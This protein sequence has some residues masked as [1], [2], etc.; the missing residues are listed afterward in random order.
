MLTRGLSNHAGCLS[1]MAGLA[2][3]LTAATA[4]GQ[5]VWTG[6][7]DGTTFSSLAN[8]N[9][10]P[11][12]APTLS[13]GNLQ[14]GTAGTTTVTIDAA[15]TNFQTITFNAGAGAFTLAGNPIVFGSIGSITNNS[16]SLQTFGSAITANS[17]RLTINAV[18]G[19]LDFTG[20]PITALTGTTF[21]VDAART[22][23]LGLI[24][25]GVGVIKNGAGTL[26]MLGAGSF[27]GGLTING[28][29]VDIMAPQ[30]FTGGITLNA[31]ELVRSDTNAFGGNV[32]SI[33]AGTLTDN[34]TGDITNSLSVD[35]NFTLRSTN[36]TP[37]ITFSGAQIDF[38]QGVRTITLADG[39]T[40]NP[41]V[42]IG[43]TV[44]NGGVIFNGAGNVNI[45]AT[46][47]ALTDLFGVD[48]T[49]TATI[50][51]GTGNPFSRTSAVNVGANATLDVT[52]TNPEWGGLT[53]S[54]TIVGSGGLFLT[55]EGAAT[56]TFSGTLTAGGATIRKAGT[57]TQ[58][59]S[60]TGA[61]ITTAGSPNAAI[62][63]EGTLSVTNGAFAFFDA[64][65]LIS[66]G[67]DTDPNVAT[68]TLDATLLI[69]PDATLQLGGA[70]DVGGITTTSLGGTASSYLI[71]L[72]G[73]TS[74]LVLQAGTSN[75]IG[76]SI[77]GT[78]ATSVATLAGS[79]TI[80]TDVSGSTADLFVAA[81]SSLIPG[82]VTQL[83]GS[84]FIIDQGDSGIGSL[85]FTDV[86]VTVEAGGT[87]WARIGGSTGLQSSQLLVNRNLTLDANSTIVVDLVGSGFVGPG[88]EFVIADVDGTLSA[89]V[90][91]ITLSP[92]DAGS[93]TF[94]VFTSAGNDQLIVR[95]DTLDNPF[96][97][98][99]DLDNNTSIG[100]SF[101]SIANI[102]GADRTTDQNSLLGTLT[103]IAQT[104]TVQYNNLIRGINDGVRAQPFAST[105]GLRLS[106]QFVVAQQEYVN[107]RLQGS[108]TI[109][110]RQ[111]TDTFGAGA[112][113]DAFLD[114]PTLANASQPN[115]DNAGWNRIPRAERQAARE[116]E[117][118]RAVETPAGAG[119]VT[120]PVTNWGKASGFETYAKAFGVF[121][122]EDS[123][124]EFTGFESTSVGGQVG[125][126]T[127]FS[128][129]LVGL[130]FSYARS[131]LDLNDN[132][133]EVDANTYRIGPYYAWDLTDGY[134][135]FIGDVS[136]N[137]G[138]HDLEGERGDALGFYDYETEAYDVTA[139]AGLGYRFA[140]PQTGFSFTPKGTLLFQYYYQDGY[141]ESGT[142]LTRSDV[143]SIDLTQVA[144]R[145][146]NDLAY[147]YVTDSGRRIIPSIGVGYLG[148]VD[149]N[150]GEIDS[151]FQVGGIPYVV[152]LDTEG[153][154]SVLWNVG[155]IGDITDRLSFGVKYEQQINAER[156]GQVIEGGI[157]WAF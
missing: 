125:I 136:I 54:G 151:V 98:V 116:A 128:N 64:G 73:G 144:I 156:F 41:T 32:V 133:G 33:V 71:A 149:Y 46:N 24:T 89:A 21:N 30:S 53:G 111:N 130:A 129:Q 58:V 96:S 4:S 81:G 154:H 37:T 101:D 78:G 28:G 6:A 153:R 92:D 126:H 99:V 143:G 49:V 113:L 148:V 75:N 50:V 90:S 3:S 34:A 87:Y 106:N 85:T 17:G 127:V 44:G 115:Y 12:T 27:T 114:R 56:T 117:A 105:F 13:N 10:D 124:E 139:A 121:I 102:P 25:G 45:D 20:A 146:N 91:N 40:G 31:G 157:Y 63:S 95:I 109:A 65:L 94:T 38:S 23:T 123:N 61:N 82:G 76:T 19:D 120:E 104:S 84:N 36:S 18:S 147:E 7:G 60:G 141:S 86:N 119:A 112:A 74:N 67:A 55:F 150:T 14:F 8:W 48:G 140:G 26:D 69:G 79:G 11:G 15:F 137:F 118:Q 9:T 52:N 122:D 5:L 88:T 103:N 66:T 51:A 72:S 47:V 29:V 142:G 70:L 152:E 35:G 2:L 97:R 145:L 131:D 77:P 59:F 83:G 39:G 138:F 16:S 57:G 80:S 62:L 1:R 155:L 110:L 134:T 107:A 108:P 43:G 68:H 22:V 100:R 135:G 93:A 42:N 132:F